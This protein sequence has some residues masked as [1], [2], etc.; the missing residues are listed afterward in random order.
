[1]PP[2]AGVFITVERD[3]APNPDNVR[4]GLPVVKPIH[5]HILG[6]KADK[7]VPL[8]A[9]VRSSPALLHTLTV[10]YIGSNAAEILPICDTT[11][12]NLHHS[13]KVG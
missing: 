5:I 9:L 11:V 7:L 10:G 13:N 12:F 2:S 3:S 4:N 8:P 1:V 6:F